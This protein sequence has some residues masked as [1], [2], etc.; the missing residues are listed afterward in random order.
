MKRIIDL[1]QSRKARHEKGGLFRDTGREVLELLEARR[2]QMTEEFMTFLIALAVSD[3]AIHYAGE[4][5]DRKAGLRFIDNV[6]N[7]VRQLFETHY[8]SDKP[9]AVPESGRLLPLCREEVPSG[10]T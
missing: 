6:F 3:Q 4:A 1:A 7:T 8:L 10:K 2:R 5:R 9:K